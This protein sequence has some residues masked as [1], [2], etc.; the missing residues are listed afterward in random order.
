MSMIN[1]ARPAMTAIAVVIALTATPALAQTAP[2][3]TEV[4]TPTTIAPATVAPAAPA[5]EAPASVTTETAAPSTTETVS[6]TATAAEAVPVAKAKT[7]QAMT[8]TAVTKTAKVSTAPVKDAPTPVQQAVPAPGAV[9]PVAPIVASTPEAAPAAPVAQSTTTTKRD[10]TLPIAAGA[11]LGILALVGGAFALRRRRE[12]DPQLVEEVIVADP[13][14][15]EPAPTPMPM[16]KPM[17][18]AAPLPFDATGHSARVQAAYAGPS[19]DNPSLSLK[20]RVKRAS[21]LDQM[22]RNGHAVPAAPAAAPVRTNAST[23]VQPDK[24]LTFGLK[25]AF[26]PA[27]Q[28]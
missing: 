6:D 13:V 2:A 16:P 28:S 27:Y 3:A 1:N 12:D 24:G 14:M 22:E 8:K 19:D 5:V 4:P 20:K 26:R 15:A 9:T 17:V 18:A 25:P 23:W 11:G 10:D 21:A 7:R